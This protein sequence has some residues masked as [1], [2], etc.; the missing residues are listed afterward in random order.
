MNE[1][2]RRSERA[3]MAESTGIKT[4]GRPGAGIVHCCGLWA[5]SNR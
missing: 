4:K 1:K 5:P 3:E 2:V